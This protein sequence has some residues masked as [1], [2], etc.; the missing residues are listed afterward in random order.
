MVEFEYDLNREI[1][2]QDIVLKY[3]KPKDQIYAL[4]MFYL[5]T[6]Y[7]GALY[8]I[9]LAY[10]ELAYENKDIDQ[11]K[12][13][14]LYYQ[15]CLKAAIE[16]YVNAMNELVVYYY[17]K[18]KYELYKAEYW[19]QKLYDLSL[20]YETNLKSESLYHLSIISLLKLVY[21]YREAEYLDYY[22]FNGLFK[23]AM[24]IMKE[25][26]DEARY[27]GRRFIE[28]IESERQEDHFNHTKDYFKENFETYEKELK[29]LY[30]TSLMIL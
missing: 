12:I 18:G 20:K 15:Y 17:N 1:E 30:K 4:N 28:L 16:G 3:E 23:D 19:A 10:D 8:F 14:D 9:A 25:L 2:I 7:P 21:Y 27:S 5:Q 26:P 24:N 22:N 6:K 11:N 13:D 29:E